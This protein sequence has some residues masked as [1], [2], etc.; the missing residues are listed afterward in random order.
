VYTGGAVSQIAEADRLYVDI[1]IDNG[2]RQLPG[3]LL[4]DTGCTLELVLS[5]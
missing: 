5:E 4:L 1:M 2:S 3:S